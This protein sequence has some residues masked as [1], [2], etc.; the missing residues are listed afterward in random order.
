MCSKVNDVSWGRET[1]EFV[2]KSIEEVGLLA[3]IDGLA[4]EIEGD[5]LVA[6]HVSMSVKGGG[7]VSV[8]R[9]V[10]MGCG[11][12]ETY[13]ICL[14]MVMVK[15]M[16]KY[17]RRMGQKTGMSKALEAVARMESTMA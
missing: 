12:S 4:S 10:A 17:M 8:A 9:D 15:R 2:R 7:F 1:R 3:P 11:G 13:L 5:V 16:Q 14:R 6:D